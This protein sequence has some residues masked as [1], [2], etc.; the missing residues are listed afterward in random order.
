[1]LI[2]VK[3]LVNGVTIVADAGP[4]A[5]SLMYY[6]IELDTH[7]PIL[8]EGLAVESFLCGSPHAFDN[9]DDYLRLYGSPGEPLTPFA[10]YVRPPRVGIAYPQRPRSHLRSPK[11]NRQVARP[12]CRTR[13]VCPRCLKDRMEN[14]RTN[15]AL[16]GL[17]VRSLIAG[18]LSTPFR[19]A[20]AG[21][22]VLFPRVSM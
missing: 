4:E 17:V 21:F 14:E 6:H 11:A 5:L 7:E 8:A 1:M 10:P 19:D 16:G 18:G 2:P 12:H 20:S 22:M 15:R 3:Y 9:A 13:R